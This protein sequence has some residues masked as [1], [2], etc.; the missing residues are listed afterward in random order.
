MN[1]RRQ[2]YETLREKELDTQMLKLMREGD[3]TTFGQ[4]KSIIH[5]LGHAAKK[6]ARHV[7]A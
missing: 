5:A 3:R 7:T 2:Q 4:W 6:Y 1:A